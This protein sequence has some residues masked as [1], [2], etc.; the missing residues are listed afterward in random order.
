[1]DMFDEHVYDSLMLAVIAYG[2][3]LCGTV[4]TFLLLWWLYRHDR[5]SATVEAESL[6][7]LVAEQYPAYVPDA[8]AIAADGGCALL[9]GARDGE[10]MAVPAGRHLVFWRLASGTFARALAERSGDGPLIIRT[11]DLTRPRVRFEPGSDFGRFAA[12]LSPPPS[13]S[14]T[15]APHQE[16]AA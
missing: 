8:A 9:I 10:A 16:F 15:H 5:P 12:H 4:V 3:A 6:A 11:G 13:A 14:A 7:A 1:M 2:T